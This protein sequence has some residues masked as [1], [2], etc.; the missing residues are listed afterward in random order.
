MGPPGSPGQNGQL[1]PPG[2]K[3]VIGARGPEGPFGAPGPGGPVGML[4]ICYNTL[5]LFAL[6]MLTICYNTLL[7][8]ALTHFVVDLGRTVCCSELQSTLELFVTDCLL[9]Y[10]KMHF[11]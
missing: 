7:L 4:T 6:T 3:G 11:V 10:G 8:F 9:A 5:L 2:P 1:G